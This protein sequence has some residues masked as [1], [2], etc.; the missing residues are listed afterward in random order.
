MIII[1]YYL[2][3]GVKN[4][5]LIK[6]KKDP[7]CSI[8][9]MHSRLLVTKKK[10]RAQTPHTPEYPKSKKNVL[11]CVLDALSRL[12]SLSPLTVWFSHP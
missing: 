8:L 1:I 3:F 6:K 10:S 7:K 12:C 5:M 9:S 4:K 11:V 2:F